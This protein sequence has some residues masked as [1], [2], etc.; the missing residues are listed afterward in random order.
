MSDQDELRYAAATI[1]SNHKLLEEGAGLRV[2]IVPSA[3]DL[4]AGISRR[5]GLWIAALPDRTGFMGLFHDGFQAVA[6]AMD[7][8]G[9]LERG[10]YY[11][12]P[13]VAG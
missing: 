11:A 4:K 8:M 2:G 6:E 12:K 10:K 9:K 13:T 1:T 7:T 5:D 3:V